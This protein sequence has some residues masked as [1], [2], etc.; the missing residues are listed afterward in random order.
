MNRGIEENNIPMPVGGSHVIPR[1][2]APYL[3]FTIQKGF[4]KDS[5]RM[6]NEEDQKGKSHKRCQ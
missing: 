3:Y 1:E 4:L 2:F 6:M 5:M